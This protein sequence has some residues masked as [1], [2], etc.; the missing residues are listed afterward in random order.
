MKNKK[1]L[2]EKN[3]IL[4]YSIGAPHVGKANLYNLPVKTICGSSL[5]LIRP[6]KQLINPYYLL[7]FLNSLVGR[8]LTRRN[9]RGSVQQCIYPFD[10]EKVPIPELDKLIQEQIEIII[11]EG[12]EAHNKSKILLTICKR[13]VETLIETNEKTAN[14]FI[15]T[16]LQKLSIVI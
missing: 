6:M 7:V 2:L 13:A 8:L 9:L 11:R 14:E 4:L 16:E 10:T 3:D 12:E 5:T 1:Y 15:D